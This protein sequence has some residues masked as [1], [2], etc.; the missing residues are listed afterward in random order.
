[1]TEKDAILKLIDEKPAEAAML[2]KT[3]LAEDD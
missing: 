1:M 3:W 2:I